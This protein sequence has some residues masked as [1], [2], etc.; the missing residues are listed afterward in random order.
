[1]AFDIMSSKVALP[2]YEVRTLPPP[3][4]ASPLP[5]NKTNSEKTTANRIAKT[6]TI[7]VRIST[8]YK[9]TYIERNWTPRACPI[10]HAIPNATK[11]PAIT[12]SIPLFKIRAKGEGTRCEAT[13]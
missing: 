9:D 4:I 12:W 10:N 8:S 6:R 13:E 1:M 3:L 2:L 11:L 5:V 7:R